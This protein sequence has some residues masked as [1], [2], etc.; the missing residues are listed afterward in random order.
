VK[1]IEN[2]EKMTSLETWK[3]GSILIIIIIF[4]NNNNNMILEKK[5]H[6]NI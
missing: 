1:K 2:G 4:N 3:Y 5:I 6:I